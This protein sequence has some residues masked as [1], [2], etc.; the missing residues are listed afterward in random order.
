MTSLSNQC[1]SGSCLWILFQ[2]TYY[3]DNAKKL[4]SAFQRT[5]W[6]Q[7]QCFTHTFQLAVTDA[8]KEHSIDNLLAKGRANVGHY[9]H[10]TVTR[11]N[12]H[13]FQCQLE[14]LNM[15]CYLW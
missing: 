2:P 15:N 11:E 13:K 10:S 5:T 1:W 8:K 7:V 3:S 12:L 6:H 14:K 4:K 9:R